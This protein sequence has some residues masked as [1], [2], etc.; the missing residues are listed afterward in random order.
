MVSSTM[1]GDEPCVRPQKCSLIRSRLSSTGVW[2]A[3]P[4]CTTERLEHDEP[5]LLHDH[6][7]SANTF[8]PAQGS[9]LRLH[10]PAQGRS[11]YGS[12]PIAGQFI[13]QSHQGEGT[14][15]HLKRGDVTTYQ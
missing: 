1:S 9:Y 8:G 11:M 2:P 6:T 13:I 12:I 3:Q 14:T 5:A 4:Y 7:G 10:T 15:G